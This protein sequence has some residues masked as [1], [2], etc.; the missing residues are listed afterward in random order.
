MSVFRS[1]LLFIG[2]IETED[3]IKNFRALDLSEFFWEEPFGMFRQ[4]VGDVHRS[5]RGS[6]GKLIVLHLL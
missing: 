5:L 2:D 1:F 4:L 3:I 6:F